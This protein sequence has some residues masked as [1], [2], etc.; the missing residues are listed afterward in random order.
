MYV[1]TRK[2]SQ[3][4]QY[5]GVIQTLES[6]RA[7]QYEWPAMSQVATDRCTEPDSSVDYKWVIYA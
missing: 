2:H 3:E 4:V 5:D 7:Y 1:R 6:L